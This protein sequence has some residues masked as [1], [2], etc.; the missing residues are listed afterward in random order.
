MSSIWDESGTV[1]VEY[2]LVLSLLSLGFIAGMFTI[3]QAT[4]STLLKLQSELIDYG[5]RNGS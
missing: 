4:N 2:A 3:E 1:M 5:L